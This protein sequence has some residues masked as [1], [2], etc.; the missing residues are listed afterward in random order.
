MRSTIR[1]IPCLGLALKDTSLRQVRACWSVRDTGA[2]LAR[3]GSMTFR[4]GTMGREV[5]KIR[6]SPAS[7]EPSLQLIYLENPLG[8]RRGA[9][10]ADCSTSCG[11][12]APNDALMI[13]KTAIRDGLFVV[14]SAAI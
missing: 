1:R 9:P 4:A 3:L 11:I 6:S 2:P 12:A 8:W 14:F 7:S 5:K 10:N 13:R